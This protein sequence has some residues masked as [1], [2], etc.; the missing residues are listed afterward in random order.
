MFPL[1]LSGGC[2]AHGQFSLLMNVRDGFVPAMIINAA[3]T[4]GYCVACTATSASCVIVACALIV[5][6]LAVVFAHPPGVR[7]LCTSV[8]RAA[9]ACRA[10]VVSWISLLL[11][12]LGVLSFP[13]SP[14]PNLYAPVRRT[15]SPI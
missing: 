13:T 6:V 7:D 4:L 1:L 9:L 11:S 10:R 2:P 8:V 12:T 5:N 3:N 14:A 15:T